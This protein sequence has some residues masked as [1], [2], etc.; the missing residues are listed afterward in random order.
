MLVLP[1]NKEISNDRT[2]PHIH[3]ISRLDEFSRSKNLQVH[4]GTIQSEADI[5]PAYS[6]QEAN[7]SASRCEPDMLVWGRADILEEKTGLVMHYSLTNPAQFEWISDFET[8]GKI[9][10]ILT[11]AL[12]PKT[13][14]G[15]TR[16]IEEVLEK[17]IESTIAYKNGEYATVINITETLPKGSASSTQEE[18]AT[19]FLQYLGAASYQK[20]NQPEKAIATYSD[21]LEKDP[22]ATLAL[23]NRAHLQF[24]QKKYNKALVDFNALETLDKANYE[25]LYK[26]AEAHEHLGNLGAAKEDFEKAE[27]ICPP[28]VKK[29]IT[30]HRQQVEKKIKIE[31]DKIS[32]ANRAKPKRGPKNKVVPNTPTTATR[33]LSKAA[34]TEQLI[35]EAA[36]QNTIGNAVLAEEKA[37]E[38]LKTQPTN[39]KALKELIRA[40]YF[41]DHSISI[42]DLKKNPYLS[43]LDPATLQKWNDDPVLEVVLRNEMIRRKSRKRG[44]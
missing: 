28:G 13:Y 23:N 39:K 32:K 41:Q 36:Q 21:I 15:A 40:K 12:T 2:P 42:R 4:I 35:T 25:V 38:I 44:N 6:Q 34:Q 5:E 7:K 19:M 22:I 10:T 30:A 26:K 31:E 14:E 1:F 11:D 33:P 17:I 3:I 20:T 9:D 16:E 27:S 8:D 24:K 29:T 18:E 37:I 43:G